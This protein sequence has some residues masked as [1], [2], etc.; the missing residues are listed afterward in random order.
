VKHQYEQITNHSIAKQIRNSNNERDKEHT[1]KAFG[2]HQFSLCPA[3][4]GT[5]D[6]CEGRT[7]V[8]NW[9]A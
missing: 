1:L 4:V 8:Q 2:S 3:L 5:A 6:K 9:G 7:P